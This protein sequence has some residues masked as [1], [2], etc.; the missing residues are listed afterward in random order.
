MHEKKECVILLTG[1]II[2]N[3]GLKDIAHKDS[4]LR[5]QEYLKAIKYYTQ[6]GRVVLV[7]NSIYDFDEDSEFAS[8]KGLKI[9]KCPSE[10]DASSGLGAQEFRMVDYWIKNAVDLPERWIKVTGRYIFSNFSSLYLQSSEF[11]EK[12]IFERKLFSGGRVRTDIFSVTTDFY[13]K[14]LLGSYLDMNDSKGKWAEHVFFDRLK[15]E[16][17]ITVFKKHPVLV[18]ISGSTGLPFKHTIKNKF[19]DLVRNRLY[20]LIKFYRL[21]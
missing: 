2:P 18:G 19:F 3:L 8:I 9:F 20:T 11:Q 1:T 10:C 6:F 5:R 13:K 12:M 15:F 4:F 16:K 21:F 14:Y 17:N 7:E